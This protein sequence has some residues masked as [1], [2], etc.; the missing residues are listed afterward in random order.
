MS[1]NTEHASN[2][3][4]VP[5]ILEIFLRLSLCRLLDI[6]TQPW[7]EKNRRRLSVTGSSLAIRQ[8]TNQPTGQP[9]AKINYNA[10][11]HDDG[12]HVSRVLNAY[13]HQST[14]GI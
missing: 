14:K 10:I 7:K 3:S 12:P 5:K 13:Q 6:S 2:D 8:P 1:T 4:L 9:S 11:Q